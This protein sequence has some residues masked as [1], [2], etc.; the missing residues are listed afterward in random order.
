MDKIHDPYQSV[1]P[2][3]FSEALGKV[4]P[5]SYLRVQIAGE[6]DFGD[7][8]TTFRLIP[9][10]GGDTGEER[11]ENL[12]LELYVDGDRAF[13][14]MVAFGSLAADIGFDFDQEIIEISAPV[15]RWA[16]EWMW[17]PGFLLFGLIYMMQKRRREKQ[18]QS[19]QSAT[20]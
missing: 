14:D 8:M 4:D 12:G 11:M 5:G 19:L 13:V 7:P 15:D 10:P 17:I 6:D 2:S 9:V 16:K 18:E 1:P 3:Q 20:A